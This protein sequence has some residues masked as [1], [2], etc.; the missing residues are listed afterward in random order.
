MRVLRFFS[1]LFS[2]LSAGMVLSHMLEMR[3]KMRMNPDKYSNTEAFDQT[4]SMASALLDSGAVLFSL[5]LLLFGRRRGQDR[6]AT[7]VGIAALSAADALWASG[8]R[9]VNDQVAAWES[10][11]DVPHDWEAERKR[12]EVSTTARAVL[13]VGA[14][15]ALIIAS[16]QQPEPRLRDVIGPEAKRLHRRASKLAPKTTSRVEDVIDQLQPVAQHFLHE[17]GRHAPSSTE[18]ARDRMSNLVEHAQPALMRFLHD[19][20]KK[21]PVSP[22]D[23]RDAANKAMRRARKPA[24]RWM[25]HLPALKAS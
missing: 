5:P 15:G 6:K 14:L 12:L 24:R 23:A 1:L 17:A 4:W 22:E 19:T 21:S 20:S 11:L 7:L 2:A 9:P 8:N 3:T 16:Q 13:Q 18:D 25:Q 10:G